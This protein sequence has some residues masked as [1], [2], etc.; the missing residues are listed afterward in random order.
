M[1]SNFQIGPPHTGFV[2]ECADLHW[3]T[4]CQ[5]TANILYIFIFW[6]M[7]ISRTMMHGSKFMVAMVA[8]ASYGMPLVM[9]GIS[10]GQV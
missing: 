3:D 6:H 7:S 5:I 4:R 1:A 9:N 8:N 2:P 10:Q